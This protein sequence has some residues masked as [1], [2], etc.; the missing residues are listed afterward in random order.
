MKVVSLLIKCLFDTMPHFRLKKK[1]PYLYGSTIEYFEDI[2]AL[3]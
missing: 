2:P 3:E 1:K